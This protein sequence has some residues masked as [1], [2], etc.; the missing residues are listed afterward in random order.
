MTYT[1]DVS[2]NI[3]KVRLKIGDRDIT[4]TTDAQF[5]D[6]EIQIFL[7]EAG[8]S[9]LLAASL[10]LEAWASNISGNL[11]AEKIGDYS[12]T[13]KGV[14][15]KIALAKKYRDEDASLPAMAWSEMDLASVGEL[16]LT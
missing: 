1:Y 2:D 11:S 5:N 9:I 13:S 6:A 15:N 16:P 7:D 12:Y 14:E 3:G 10:A 4:P 8:N